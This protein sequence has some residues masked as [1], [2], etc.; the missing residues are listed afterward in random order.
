MRANAVGEARARVGAQ[1]GTL[2]AAVG[3]RDAAALLGV[4]K[5]TLGSY[6]TAGVP[7]DPATLAA[8]DAR[9]APYA[10]RLDR[11]SSLQ[12]EHAAARE[13]RDPL[14]QTAQQRAALRRQCERISRE[15]ERLRAALR[16]D[17]RAA[18][19]GRAT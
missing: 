7:S 4:S 12:A 2:A 16:A 18:L 15:R 9:L 8:R 14:A 5:T 10:A 13:G 3:E 17:V 19:A 11:L 6:R 1:L